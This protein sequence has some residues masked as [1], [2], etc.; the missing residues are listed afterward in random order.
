[1]PGPQNKIPVTVITGYL[2][3]GKTTL[4]RR[5][6]ASSAARNVAVLVNEVAELGI[7]QRL[8]IAFAGDVLLL[9]NGCVCCSIQE[10]LRACLLGLLNRGGSA[11]AVSRVVIETTGLADPVPILNT[12]AN[13][14]VLKYHF[15]IWKVIATVDCVNA[16]FQLD[17]YPECSKQIAVADQVLLTKT[18]LVDPG[19]VEKLRPTLQRLNPSVPILDAAVDDLNLV[20]LLWSEL[21]SSADSGSNYRRLIA[22]GSTRM[23]HDGPVDSALGTKR[24][25]LSITSFCISIPGAFDWSAFALWL[26]MLLHAHGD[27]VLRVK[28]I[29]NIADSSTPLLINGVQHLMHKPAHLAAWPDEE[30]SSELVFIV[31]GLDPQMIRNSLQICVGEEI[32][33]GTEILQF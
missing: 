13:D 27:K 16:P 4:L 33:T 10:D 30:R 29:L 26:T 6:L 17:R 8:L 25:D 31:S 7:D 19:A 23:N 22:S 21:S 5:I 15:E 20:R 9:K 11:G 2:G 3:S 24:H 28:G 18:D 32:F 14:P 12:F 1:M